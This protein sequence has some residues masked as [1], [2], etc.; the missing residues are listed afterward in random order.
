MKK[1]APNPHISMPYRIHTH[2]HTHTNLSLLTP[3]DGTLS[4]DDRFSRDYEPP[5]LDAT[6]SKSFLRARTYPSATTTAASSF[7]SSSSSSSSSSL[8]MSTAE[9]EQASLRPQAAK[10]AGT[11]ERELDNPLS[12]SSPPSLMPAAGPLILLLAYALLSSLPP[13]LPPSLLQAPPPTKPRP[14]SSPCPSTTARTRR[15]TPAYSP[16]GTCMSCGP[17]ER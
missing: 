12:S 13:S 2:T 10:D 3:Q 4:F 7:P 8:S 6:Q 16:G 1:A 5:T 11:F 15:R 14:L 17:G 9:R